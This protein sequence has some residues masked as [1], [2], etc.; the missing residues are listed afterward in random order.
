MEERKTI[1]DYLS[2]IMVVFGLSMLI[3]NI[4]CLA[5]GN[6]AKG[7][8]TMFK[9]GNQGVPVETAFE[10]LCVSALITGIRFLFFTD[11]WIKKMPLWAR[12]ICML[13]SIVIVIAVFIIIFGW[14]PIDMWVPWAMFFI[15]FGFSFAISCFVMTIKEKAENR[16][17][18]DALERLLEKE[19]AKNG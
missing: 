8:S 6:S 17:M 9:L 3:M 4:F 2:Q 18:K 13:S 5:F 19:N 15:C 12:T 14:F 16:K 7:F 11:I 1:F 10:F